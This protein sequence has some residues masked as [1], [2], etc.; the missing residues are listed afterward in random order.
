MCRA[1][2]IRWLTPCLV[3]SRLMSVKLRLSSTTRYPRQAARH[4]NMDTKQDRLQRSDSEGDLLRDS[5]DTLGATG[6]V[7]R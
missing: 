5:Q 1:Y 3:D 4:A 2:S 6:G 7:H